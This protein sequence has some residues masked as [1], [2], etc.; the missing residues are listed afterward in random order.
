MIQLLPFERLDPEF[1]PLIKAAQVVRER[2]YA[3]YTLY[4]VGC[5]ILADNGRIYTGANVENAAYPAAMCA[6]AT[7]VAAMVS[8]GPRS[9]RAVV[10]ANGAETPV[11]PCGK[12]RQVIREFGANCKVVVIGS[13]PLFSQMKFDE[14]YP[15]SFGPKEMSREENI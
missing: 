8:D 15:H 7:A 14:L 4:R 13:S 6:E 9:I 10:V 1:L 11:F 2:A 12:C 3:P 5:A